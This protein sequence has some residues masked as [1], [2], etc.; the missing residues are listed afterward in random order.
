MSQIIVTKDSFIAMIEK[1]PI[2][3]VGRA[4]VV[5]FNNQTASE[6]ATKDTRVTNGEGFTKADA[7]GGT[8]AAKSYLKNNTLAGWQVA[9]WTRLDK[10]GCPR[11]AKYW[12]Q[13]NDAAIA[14]KNAQTS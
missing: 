10:K 3:A 9:K 12:R 4:L 14:K 5:L 11:I 1:N 7:W 8:L 13:L 2:H 6:Q